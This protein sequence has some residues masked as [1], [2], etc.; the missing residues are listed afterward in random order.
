MF[1]IKIAQI[2]IN[3]INKYNFV[4]EQCKDYVSYDTPN[5]NIEATNEEIENEKKNDNLP[6]GYCESIC[7]YRKICNQIID[8]N[9]FLLHSSVVCVNNEAYAFAAKSG[10]GKSTQTNLWLK[11]FGEKATVINGDKPIYRFENDVLNVYGTP[12]CGKEG[13]NSNTYAPLKVIYFIE[14]STENEIYKLN[15]VQIINKI[16]HQVIIPN[17]LQKQDK[18]MNMIDRVINT[19]PC[20]CLKCNIS[21]E[22]VKIAYNK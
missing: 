1:K 17:E 9:A 22:A 19:I 3:I 15:N 13:L 14:R 7:I 6:N 18:F 21:D 5:F 16:F 4:F 10:V 20:Y 12:W 8:Y 2:T 11:H